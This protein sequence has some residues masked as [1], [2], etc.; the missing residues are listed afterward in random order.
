M[1]VHG[2]EE[3]E[4]ALVMERIRQSNAKKK[5]SYVTVFVGNK[6]QLG[7]TQ[8]GMADVLQK[9]W[10]A[11]ATAQVMRDANPGVIHVKDGKPLT[12][13]GAQMLGVPWNEDS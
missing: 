4:Q 6:I 10:H 5:R 13:K 2:G 12:A 3:I 11:Q 1:P 9:Q 7:L 8:A